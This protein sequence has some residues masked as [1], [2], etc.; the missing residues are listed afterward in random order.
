MPGIMILGVVRLLWL[1]FLSWIVLAFGALPW[2][3]LIITLVQ[4]MMVYVGVFALVAFTPRPLMAW[5]VALGVV[6]VYPIGYMV[7]LI[8]TLAGY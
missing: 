1:L 8:M 3:I 7:F 5:F 4:R 2:T 6:A